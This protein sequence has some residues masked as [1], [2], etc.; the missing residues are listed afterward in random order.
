ML[1]KEADLHNYAVKGFE[2]NSKG[3]IIPFNSSIIDPCWNY[4]MAW[5]AGRQMILIV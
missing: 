3:N 4:K 5:I 2:G 1:R